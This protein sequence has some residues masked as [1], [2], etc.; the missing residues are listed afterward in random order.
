MYFLDLLE[1]PQ[2]YVLLVI[3]TVAAVV[4]EY[5]KQKALERNREDLR[6]LIFLVFSALWVA[7]L[8]IGGLVLF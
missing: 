2:F 3:G 5:F 7:I 8:V 6:A 1:R 4:A